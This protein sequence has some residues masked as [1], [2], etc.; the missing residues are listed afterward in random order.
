M[1][2]VLDPVGQDR[3]GKVSWQR[4][5]RIYRQGVHDAGEDHEEQRPQPDPAANPSG[6][7][8]ARCPQSQ[9]PTDIRP[10]QRSLL[11]PDQDKHQRELQDKAEVEAN[12]Q[13]V[14]KRVS[15]LDDP[16]KQG[17]DEPAEDAHRDG[18][19]GPDREYLTKRILRKLL[20]PR[21][22]NLGRGLCRCR[23][24]GSLPSLLPFSAVCRQATPGGVPPS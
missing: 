9:R 15:T 3:G 16:A 22:S 1:E 5:R 4:P 8:V 24:R 2:V 20:G 13:R 18:H 10:C 6:L 19:R 17:R 7:R 21:V 14:D 12:Q 23:R 11:P